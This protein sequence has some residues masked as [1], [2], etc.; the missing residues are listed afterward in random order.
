MVTERPGA[1]QAED[2][3]DEAPWRLDGARPA[4]GASEDGLG[5]TVVRI[6]KISATGPKPAMGRGK[7]PSSRTRPSGDAA[8]SRPSIPKPGGTSRSGAAGEAKAPGAGGAGAPEGGKPSTSGRTQQSKRPGDGS[9]AG[10]QGKPGAPRG[11]QQTRTDDLM[12]AFDR[13]VSGKLPSASAPV[14]TPKKPDFAAP[15]T[16]PKVP[17]MAAPVPTVASATAK[18]QGAPVPVA[19]AP[20]PAGAPVRRTRKARLRLSRID[21]WSV[22]KTVFLFSIA[23][24]IMSWVATYLLWQILLSS[25]LFAALNDAVLSIISSPSNSEGW[26]IE[27]YLS[28]NKVL[29]VTAL[30]AVINVVITTALGTLGAFLYNLSANIL[31]GLELTLAED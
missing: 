11:T 10:Q 2:N 18:A 17:P 28:A 3:A 16:A 8:G 5:D 27:D 15:T 21:P 19:G 22:M 6:P 30:L 14:T 12:A 26:R 1:K 20:K 31:G 25:G 9:V 29:G 24:G 23:F 13:P 7:A 4:P